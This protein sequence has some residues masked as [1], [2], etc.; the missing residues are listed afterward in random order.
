MATINHSSGTDIIVPSSNGTTYRGLAG[1]DTYIISNSIA[2][3]AAITIVDTSGS[4][5]IQLVDGLSIASSKFA[6]DAVQLTLNNGAVVTINGASNFTFDVGGNSTSGVTGSSKTLSTFASDMGVTTLPSSGSSDGSSNVSISGNAVSSTAAPSYTVTKSGTSVDEGGSLTF[7][8]T[9]SAAVTADTDFSWTVIG[10]NNGSTVDKAGT[11]DL[12][13]VSGTATIASGASSTTFSIGAASDGVVEGIEGIKV[14]VFDS[15]SSTV[16]S[17][18]VLINN[19]GSASPSV[20][21]T[22]TTGVDIF[23]GGSGD[24]SFDAAGTVNTLNDTDVLDGGAGT[25]SLTV[26]TTGT[27][28]IT[29]QT[30]GI[31][32]LIVTNSSAA[33]TTLTVDLEDEADFN[34]L[35]NIASTDSV[36]FNNIQQLSSVTLNNTIDTTVIDYDKSV[37]AGTSDSMTL[38]LKGLASSTIDINSD[39]ATGVYDLE[40][41]NIVTS[42]AASVV[43]DL[44]TDG[45]D[46]A[47]INISGNKDL[48]LS[49][50]ADAEVTTIDAS[51]LTG[52]L[53][54]SVLPAYTLAT[55]TGG[56]GADTLRHAGGAANTSGGAGND[57]I[58]IDEDG[59][60]SSLLG[61][62]ATGTLDTIDGGAGDDTVQIGGAAVSSATPLSGLT[63]VE[64]VSMV[65]AHG[66]T[67]ASN[68]VP[69]DFNFKDG[70]HQV[71]TLNDGYT[72]ATTVSI[73]GDVN[74]GDSVINN[75]NV[76]LTVTAGAADIDT[77]TTLTGG[78]GNDTLN[79]VNDGGEATWSTNISSFENITVLDLA[80][81]TGGDSTITMSAYALGATNP[82]SAVLTVDASALDLGENFTFTGASA[83]SKMDITTGAGNDTIS[84]GTLADTID[85]GAGNDQITT[86]TGSNH[87]TAGSGNDTIITDGT[88]DDTLLGGDGNDTFTLAD[89]FD[90]ADVITGGAGTDIMTHTANITSATVLG[91]MSEIE[92]IRPLAADDTAITITLAAPITDVSQFDL[93]DDSSARLTL[94]ATYT[95][96]VEVFLSKGLRGTDGTDTDEGTN[97]DSVTNTAGVGL[98]VYATVA[99]IDSG[100]TLTGGAGTD[101]LVLY[102]DDSAATSDFTAVTKFETITVTD[103]SLNAGDDAFLDLKS[104]ATP[105][106]VDGT[107]LDAGEQLKVDGDSATA[108]GILTVKGGESADSIDGGAA[109]DIIHGNGGA[110]TLDGNGGIDNISGGAANDSILIH[111]EGEFVTAYGY[112]TVDG[113]AGTDTLTFDTAAVALSAAEIANVSNVEVISLFTGSS[114]VVS[115]AFLTAN[116]G[117]SIRLAGNGTLSGGTDSA[118]GALTTEAIN[119]VSTAAGNVNV[120][121]GSADD[122]FTFAATET[123]T[124]EDTLNGLTGDDTIYIQNNDDPTANT[125]G[126]STT[127]TFD[128]D[129]TN[130]E[131]IVITDNSVDNSAGDV[132]ITIHADY[133]T[134]ALAGTALNIDASQLD[135]NTVTLANSEA[136]TL[137]NNDS[138]SVTVTGGTGHDSIAAGSGTSSIVGGAGNDTIDGEAGKDTLHGGDGVDSIIGGAGVDS[139]SAG[140]GNDVIS[141]DDHSDFQ[142]SGGA[143]TVDGGIGTDKLVF[144]ESNV[145]ITL[146]APEVEQL[147]GVE[148]IEFANGSGAA[149]I[150]LGNGTWTNNTGVTNLIID[151][152]ANTGAGTTDASAVSNGAIT[153]IGSD[154]AVDDSHKG[155]SGDDIFRWVDSDLTADDTLDGNGG[156]DTVQANTTGGNVTL[157]L[158]WD[159]HTDLEQVVIYNP[160]GT[161][162]GNLIVTTGAHTT[163]AYNPAAFTIDGSAQLLTGTVAVN[164]AGVDTITTNYTITGGTAADTLKGSKGNDTIDGGGTTTADSLYG[165]SGNDSLDGNEGADSIYGGK[166][167]DTVIGNGGADV[168][169][170]HDADGNESVLDGGD[171]ISGGSG[172]DSIYGQ[173]GSD[174]LTGGAGNDNFYYG[175]T[176]VLDGAAGGYAYESKG[177]T[178]DTITDFTAAGDN[179]MISMVMA[180]GESFVSNDLGDVANTGEAN[181]VFTGSAGDMI[182]IDDVSRL[183]IDADG[184]GVMDG[185]DFQ[186]NLTGNTGFADSDINYAIAGSTGANTMYGGGGSDTISSGN[187]ADSMKGNAGADSLTGGTG[188]S[189]IFGGAG[190]DTVA[191]GTGAETLTGGISVATGTGSGNDSITSGNG[192]DSIYGGD[193]NDTITGGTGASQIFGEAG[194][195]SLTGGTGT[196][197]ISGG[198]GNDTIQGAA[199]A[200]ASLD[201]GA[202]NDTHLKPTGLDTI[203]GGAGNDIY[204][205]DD[206]IANQ[207]EVTTTFTTGATNPDKLAIDVSDY[208]SASE[209]T[210]I[211]TST[212]LSGT[213][214]YVS[215]VSL[216]ANNATYDISGDIVGGTTLVVEFTGLTNDANYDVSAT[217]QTDGTA[218][219]AALA[220]AT[221]TQTITTLTVDSG[222]AFYIV[223]IDATTGD[224]GVWF[225]DAGDSNTIVAVGEV[226][227][228]AMI[229]DVTLTD[230]SFTYDNFTLVD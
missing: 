144:S 118:G 109:N 183:V 152:A 158:D 63:N 19:V 93:S 61:S 129:V 44:Q 65:T 202:G 43:T 46:V 21:K 53:T 182:F 2:A 204:Y 35:T 197:T 209:G 58:I 106:T 135:Q 104:Y 74:S 205:M 173:E 37:L 177:I 62:G 27:Q 228:V 70:D 201:G 150:T 172:A 41:L 159:T 218:L 14:S 149:T 141:V 230:G 113:G 87:I 186:V 102:A 187:G 94:S 103:N 179:L 45:V 142:T 51:E 171:S 4:N 121:G 42:S 48:T 115:D 154:D 88:G 108:A 178:R 90:S 78:L 13:A 110:D 22:L 163:A 105:L 29:P 91:G 131:N 56:S 11:S 66:I 64:T 167:A 217:G 6:A 18:V 9:S 96:D 206:A 203:I 16:S 76:T 120:T 200:D 140:A 119:F 69:T 219:F 12:D 111:S 210:D 89:D 32:T 166:G 162:T 156:T 137:D 138:A 198:T 39:D 122:S 136:L 55:I 189:Q 73:V 174:T 57:T 100:T 215:I 148:E 98:T 33:G 23:T 147:I 213:N 97:T 220:P 30:T 146:T 82:V 117:I 229:A 176:S 107:S 222:A 195:D 116:P 196:E 17:A 34:S 125:T 193:G 85:A 139:I 227:P 5:V 79:I 128:N 83:T 133:G 181:G 175:T 31:E 169:D 160:L 112:E 67:L 164:T 28:T 184:D 207:I 157:A 221:N 212:D 50:A 10:D 123:L 52:V 208:N 127:V 77:A 130:I 15:S 155:G 211:T 114:I 71:L 1:D 95:G 54:M 190:N 192:A 38:T 180:N 80:S 165:L 99:A 223:A 26:K 3:N 153:V 59:A 40:T 151:H 68:I 126:D 24:D 49:A 185:T 194:N 191:G 224:A 8:I 86:T 216:G 36:T 143:E 60:G 214:V 75:A 72:N 7:T 132:S 124:N 84:G 101:T 168:L 225:A 145:A 47:T 20:G 92:M 81:T 161:A 25:D 199:G 226:L 188:A 134:S 170:G